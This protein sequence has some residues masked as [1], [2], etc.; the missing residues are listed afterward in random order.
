MNRIKNLI[1]FEL[2]KILNNK[3]AFLFLLVL[4]VVPI[5]SSLILLL[6]YVACRGLGLG[7]IQFMGM[8]KAIQFMF[9]GHFTLFSYIAPF[10]LALIV[11][12][13]FSTEFGRGYMKMLLITPVKRW[14]VIIAKSVSII[15]FLLIAVVLG[16]LILQT[17]LLIA[18]GITQPMGV[19]PEQLQNK[20]MDTS[21][22]MVTASS[23][24][25]L[26]VISFIANIMMIGFFIVFS[27]YFASAIL[28]AFC[29]LSAILGIH[30]FYLSSDVLKTLLS[31]FLTKG[32]SLELL[33]S[34][35]ESISK[36]FCFTRYYTDLFS[37]N[38][39][40]EI[41]NGKISIFA[42]KVTLPLGYCLVW[43]LILYGIATLIFSKKQ[44]LH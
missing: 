41:L 16:G 27:M 3:K 17:D 8:K 4:N 37:I 44:V 2:K 19:L 1:L 30:V 25:Q 13:S 11:G 6:T 26:F 7:D 5:V 34:S 23:A 42:E 9:T 35:F 12:D 22:S 32:S 31:G 14:Q 43:T 24:A 33:I 20:A 15:T 36:Y 21:L 10:F 38:L 28:M 29:S 18:R 39:I 40:Q